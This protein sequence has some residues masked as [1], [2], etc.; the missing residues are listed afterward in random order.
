MCIRDRDKTS[1]A[2]Y[3]SAATTPA[4]HVA[5]HTALTHSFG[6]YV[7]R[8]RAPLNLKYSADKDPRY[9]P[10]LAAKLGVKF[11]SVLAVP[12]TNKNGSITAILLCINKRVPSP[13]V[14]SPYSSTGKPYSSAIGHHASP[15]SSASHAAPVPAP[16]FSE[17]DQSLVEFVAVMAGS[18]LESALLFLSLI[19]I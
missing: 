11:R 16:Y 5:Y 7:F 10:D 12:V 9:D 15:S 17:Q 18:A 1:E 6:G 4:G 8:Y 2:L 14:P 19:H 13:V 3:C